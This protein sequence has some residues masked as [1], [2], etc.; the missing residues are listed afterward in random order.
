MVQN[1]DKD[2]GIDEFVEQ[3]KVDL[4]EFRRDWMKNHET[5]P[6]DWPTEMPA[7]E[8]DEQLRLFWA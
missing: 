7:G 8:W 6:L 3:M 1:T 4:E 5:A 2:I